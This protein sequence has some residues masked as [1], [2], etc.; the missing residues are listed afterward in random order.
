MRPP[1]TG[2]LSL[3][4]S[5]M[6]DLWGAA[7]KRSEGTDIGGLLWMVLSALA[8]SWMAALAKYFL[9]HTPT[10]AVVLSRGLLM[11][12]VFLTIAVKRRVS[13]IGKDPRRLLL[14]GTLGYGAVTCYFYSAQHLPVG[15]AVL[16]QYSHPVFVAALAPWILGEKTGRGHW[17]LVLTALAGIFFVVGKSGQWRG[18]AA[19]GLF[20][21]I[22]SGCAY[23]TVRHLSKTEHPLTILV[24]FTAVT[25]P[26][27]LVGTIAAGR[28][29]LPKTGAEAL[30]HVL[31][32][33]AAITGQ[34]SLT[35]GLSRAG[36]ARGTAVT[37][38]GPVFGL[39]IGWL[40]FSTVPTAASVLG[41]ALVT[42]SLILLAI[43]KP[44]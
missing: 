19:V 23:M 40:V 9:P 1:K 18:D 8:F 7:A 36:V 33:L 41:T 27:A 35:Q 11:T 20:G 2:T 4:L 17:W 32:F 6:A 14:R 24:W 28:D 12:V 38:S 39:L 37:M 34:W 3:M 29:A 25:I 43:S 22:L 13:L 30:G 44:R 26:G 10:Q 42:T 15:D 5:G 16:L 21:S 31:V